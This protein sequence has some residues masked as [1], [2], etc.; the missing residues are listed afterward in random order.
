MRGPQARA[1]AQDGGR[2][3][4]RCAGGHFVSSHCTSAKTCNCVLHRYESHAGVD[5]G[6]AALVVLC[7]GLRVKVLVKTTSQIVLEDTLLVTSTTLKRS[8]MKSLE[9]AATPFPEYKLHL[10]LAL[11]LPKT[12][13]AVR[14][15]A[16]LEV[17]FWSVCS[18][19][20]RSLHK[21]SRWTCCRTTYEENG[22]FSDPF[23]DS[24]SS[25]ARRA[26][27]LAKL[28]FFSC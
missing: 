11:T 16:N 27:D 7:V 13:D 23:L 1:S 22:S 25:V 9:R 24:S 6:A 18:V 14:T 21:D 4:D 3:D 8:P 28:V 19:G 10:G 17:T 5:W 20:R 2:E 15:W 26:K 12:A